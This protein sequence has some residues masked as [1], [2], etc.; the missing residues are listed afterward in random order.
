MHRGQACAVLD[1]IWEM[2]YTQLPLLL[3]ARGEESNSRSPEDTLA[4]KCLNVF[5][6]QPG[7]FVGL[8]SLIGKVQRAGCK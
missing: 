7:Q 4:A 5:A 3:Q 2:H 1:E 8:P 6:R